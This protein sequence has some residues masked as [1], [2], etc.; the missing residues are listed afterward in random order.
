MLQPQLPHWDQ[1]VQHITNMPVRVHNTMQPVLLQLL[2][3]C[4]PV[5]QAAP[6]SATPCP[7]ADEQSCKPAIRC[8]WSGTCCRSTAL[9][10]V[11]CASCCA[12]CCV[13]CCASCCARLPRAEGLADSLQRSAPAAA[14]T[15]R[16]WGLPAAHQD[17][18]RCHNR[19]R[20]VRKQG[21]MHPQTV[22]PIICTTP[23]QV[24]E[25]LQR[26]SELQLQHLARQSRTTR[27]G[28]RRGRTRKGA[29]E[30]SQSLE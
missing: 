7:C 13:R 3:L 25:C 4:T 11:C 18:S 23:K 21:M 16:G 6:C 19:C 12:S 15:H 28:T 20:S 27:Q 10:V 9:T 24:I 29:K 30:L 1:T 8:S 22:L 17:M 2:Q 14:A 5:L 26:L